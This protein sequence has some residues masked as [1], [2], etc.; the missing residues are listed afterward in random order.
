V[1]GAADILVRLDA[2]MSELASLLSGLPSIRYEADLRDTD[3]AH[4]A[5]Q[6]LS[7]GDEIR[8][9]HGALSFETPAR[10]RDRVRTPQD[11]AECTGLSG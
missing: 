10:T 11:E 8:I 7:G 9:N 4:C 1:P 3:N 2:T 6:H 5:P